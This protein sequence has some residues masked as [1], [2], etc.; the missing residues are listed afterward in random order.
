MEGTGACPTMRSDSVVHEGHERKYH[1]IVPES[2]CAL[3]APAPV[4]FFFHGFQDQWLRWASKLS[5][6][7]E[8]HRFVIVLPEGFADAPKPNELSWNG[9]ECCGAARDSQ[10]DDQG[11]VRRIVTKLRSTALET[12][13]P[14]VVLMDTAA[15]FAIGHSN[16]GFLAS[17]AQVNAN[18]TNGGR[19]FRGVATLAG[20]HY[21]VKGAPTAVIMHH[22]RA[23]AV[24]KY[25][26]CCSAPHADPTPGECC[27]NIGKKHGGECVGA[28][29]L[30]K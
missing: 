8:L 22:H 1:I 2:V 15:P 4:V 29:D 21:E 26:G 17:A 6:S 25:T 24:V 9:E 20:M 28:F 16:G 13:R 14:G 10:L 23:D 19:V 12:E 18:E 7:A 30:F 5:T 3:A 11:L 27:C